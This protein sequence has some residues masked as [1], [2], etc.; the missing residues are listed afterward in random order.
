MCHL[1][2][3]KGMSY[4]R[5]VKNL[6]QEGKSSNQH[7]FSLEELESIHQ[8]AAQIPFSPEALESLHTIKATLEQLKANPALVAKFLGDRTHQR[9]RG[10]NRA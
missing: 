6:S 9:G 10:T 4:K 7:A 3:R 1:D 8:Q 5:R 2:A